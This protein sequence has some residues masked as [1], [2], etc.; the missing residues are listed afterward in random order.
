MTSYET[1]RNLVQLLLKGEQAPSQELIREKVKMALSMLD[2]QKMAEGISVEEIIREI[3][4]LYSIWIPQGSI[5]EDD[6]QAHIP[7]LYDSKSSIEWD[8]WDR[9]QRYLEE[10]KGWAPS[11]VLGLDHLTD[12]VLDRLEK[13]ERSG[14]WDRR[15]MVVGQVQ[16]GK[17]SHYTG[18]ICK[19]VDSG[20][21]LIVVLSGLHKSLRSQTQM[22]LDE[23]FLGRDSQVGRAFD[24]GMKQIGVGLIPIGRE[25][26]VIPGTTSADSGDFKTN[27]ANYYNV[28]PSGSDPILM[29]VKKNKTVLN[30]LIRWA[31]NWGSQD[32]HSGKRVVRDF[33]LL[34]IDDEADNASINTKK[35]LFDKDGKLQPD[36]DATAINALIRKLL[37]SFE[38]RV[39]V[40]YTATPFANIFIHPEVDTGDHGEDLFPRNFIINLPT[41]SNYVGP[42]QVFGLNADS[43]AELDQVEGLDIVKDVDDQDE[44][45]PIGH[46]TNHVPTHLPASLKEA[47]RVF[48]LSCAV[49]IFRGQIIEHNSM[50]IHVTRWKSVQDLVTHLVNEELTALKRR[51]RL[52][53]GILLEQTLEEFKYYWEESFPQTSEAIVGTDLQPLVRIPV[54][55]DINPILN[56]AAARI[57]VKKIN[58]TAKDVLDYEEYKRKGLSLN[59]IAIGGD[60]LS[61]GLTLEGLSIS[62]Y[63]RPSKMYDTLMQMGRWF[64]YRPGYLDVCRLYTTKELVDWYRHITLASEELRKEFDRMERIGATPNDFRLKVRTHPAGLIITGISKMRNGEIMKVSFSGRIGETSTFYRDDTINLNNLRCTEEFISSLNQNFSER[65]NGNYVWGDIPAKK[66]TDFLTGYQSH[67]NS[68]FACSENLVKYIK[69]Q[70]SIG[71]LISW[72]VVLISNEASKNH[73]YKISGLDVGLTFRRNDRKSPPNEYRLIKSRLLSPLDEL[74][75]L[76]QATIDE[77]FNLSTETRR[78]KIEVALKKGSTK[79]SEKDLEAIAK[80]PNGEIVREKR[81]ELFNSEKGLLLLYTLDPQAIDSEIPVVG[82]VI[83]FPSS[84]RSE[85][86][87]YKVNLVDS[88]YELADEDED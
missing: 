32:P 31:V 63:L 66:I 81:G 74:I 30:N 76:P 57:Q 28:P 39:Y 24:T 5:L 54:W 4:T 21:K 85:A 45:M 9:Y 23:G 61:R 60:K 88:E 33:P 10:E 46:K 37:N 42:V 8:F 29:V 47:I 69:K 56:D 7:W 68:R 25:L 34:V 84:E 13:P 71:E 38:K 49:R 18:L 58:G 50:L 53:E 20:Y 6:D 77:I 67:K 27:I 70:T 52:G 12:E 55:E 87:E 17:T 79:W 3:E 86:I 44:W 41:P 80:T 16:S 72:T 62:Y 65:K 48:I 11:T 26:K 82:F 73:P 2:S 75:D 1:A 19:A 36:Q 83:S 14:S 40:G 35:L 78:K 59:V 22:R 43:V 15:G 64:G 51:L